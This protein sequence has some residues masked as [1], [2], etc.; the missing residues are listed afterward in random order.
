MAL[1]CALGTARNEWG[2]WCFP[3]RLRL[4][5]LCLLCMSRFCFPG[6]RGFTLEACIA[7]GRVA[8]LLKSLIGSRVVRRML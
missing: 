3:V 8:G 7:L 4:Y 5:G 1:L 2:S 6:L